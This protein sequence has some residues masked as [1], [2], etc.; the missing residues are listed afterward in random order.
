MAYSDAEWSALH[1]PL[2]HMRTDENHM[3]NM[4]CSIPGARPK[5]PNKC[6]EGDRYEEPT[7]RSQGG[8]KTKREGMQVEIDQNGDPEA[9]AKQQMKVSCLSESRNWIM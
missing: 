5:V 4:D 6:G 3:S 2:N 1:P 7:V 8:E 9:V